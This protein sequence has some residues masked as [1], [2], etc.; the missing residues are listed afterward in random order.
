M[1]SAMPCVMPLVTV[2]LSAPINVVPTSITFKEPDFDSLAE[3][4]RIT[5]RSG[6]ITLSDDVGQAWFEVEFYREGKLIKDKT[7]VGAGS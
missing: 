6:T 4:L 5:Q 2:L 1:G 3:I 7:I